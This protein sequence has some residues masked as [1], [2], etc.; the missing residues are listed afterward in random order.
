MNVHLAHYRH[1]F[2]EQTLMRWSSP[3]FSD[4]EAGEELRQVVLRGIGKP[5]FEAD[6]K[7]DRA[8]LLCTTRFF[9]RRLSRTLLLIS[10]FG[11]SGEAESE[12]FHIPVNTADWASPPKKARLPAK[13]VWA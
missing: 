2:T 1:V 11:T 3:H 10:R 13:R 4:N 7:F 5:L 9:L 6:L 8:Q 12:R